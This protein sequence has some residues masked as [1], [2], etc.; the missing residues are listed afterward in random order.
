VVPRPNQLAAPLG[1]ERAGDA[2][3]RRERQ[4]A[5]RV[6]VEIDERRIVVREPI[7]ERAERIGGVERLGV[8][9]GGR[10][11][12]GFGSLGRPSARSPTML[13]WISAAPPQMVSERLKKNDDTIGETE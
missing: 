6:A 9:A 3:A 8:G 13:R 10:A 12:A 7:A 4:A 5:E 1:V 2:L 11:Q